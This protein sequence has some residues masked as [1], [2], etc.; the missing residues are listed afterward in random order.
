MHET[1][2]II[3]VSGVCLS[4]SFTPLRCANTTKEI[5]VLFRVETLGDPRNM[6]N[7]EG[8]TPHGFDAAFVKLLWP[9]VIASGKN[10]SC[11]E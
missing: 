7:T 6:Y 1:R 4:R 10:S 9:H 2:T 11:R 8:R 3:D 5:E